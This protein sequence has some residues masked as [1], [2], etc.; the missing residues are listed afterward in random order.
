MYKVTEPVRVGIFVNGRTLNRNKALYEDNG[1]LYI[2][3]KGV[4][5]PVRIYRGRRIA[6]VPQEEGDQVCLT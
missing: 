5:V 4:A 1:G 3:F 6:T 2:Y